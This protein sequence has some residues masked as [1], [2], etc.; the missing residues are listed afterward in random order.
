[1]AFLLCLLLMMTSVNDAEPL[2]EA[3]ALLQNHIT[4]EELAINFDSGI[5][6]FM[7]LENPVIVAKI[8]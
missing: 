2:E 7:G 6:V 8:G 3:G 4:P 1:M 5:Q